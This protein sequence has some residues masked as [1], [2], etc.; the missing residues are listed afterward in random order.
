VARAAEETGNVALR[1]RLSGRGALA[2]GA[3]VHEAAIPDRRVSSSAHSAQSFLA[4]AIT[5]TPTPTATP[6]TAT[7][8]ATPTPTPTATATPTATPTATATPTPTPT[9]CSRRSSVGSTG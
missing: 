5:P 1:D 2:D 3:V 8:T 7:A 4:L 9:P 6:T